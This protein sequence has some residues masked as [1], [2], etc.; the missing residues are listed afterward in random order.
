MLASDAR[1]ARYQELQAALCVVLNRECHYDAA[2]L[3]LDSVTWEAVDRQ[4]AADAIRDEM[5]LLL[6]GGGDE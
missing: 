1:H 6:R 2:H 5:R 4:R 3:P